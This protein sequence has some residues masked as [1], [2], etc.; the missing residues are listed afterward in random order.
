MSEDRAF[1]V[2]GREIERKERKE[3][4]RGEGGGDKTP[5]VWTF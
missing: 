4:G 3:R 1:W 2:W 5:E